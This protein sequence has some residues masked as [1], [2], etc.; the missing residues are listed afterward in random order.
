MAR[1]LDLVKF[2]NPR[3]YF[4]IGVASLGSLLFSS[5]LRSDRP[6]IVASP[7]ET[8]LPQLSA[9]DTKK[10][11][12]PPD[13]LPGARD[14]QSPY[15]SI[16]VYEWGP[17]DGERIL[18][19]H[20]I[21]TP[22]VALTDLAHKLVSKGCRVMLFDLFGRG[23]SSGPSPS[24]HNY[25]S[26]LYTTQIHLVLSSSALS[27]SRSNPFTVIGYSLGGALALDFT[28][29]FPHLVHALIL[30]APGG[31]I[32]HSHTTWKSRL[33]YSTLGI[34]P[35]SLT[36]RLVAKRLWT[37]PETA[38]TIEP[39]PAGAVVEK[40]ET[41]RRGDAVYA[42]S[43]HN[44]LPG[45]AASSVSAVVDWQIQHHAGFVPAFISSIRYA[46]VHGE[47]GRWNVVRE[48]IENG[49]GGLK[50]VW[51]V[52]GESDPIIVAEEIVEDATSALG[53]ENVGVTIVSGVGHEV[54]IERAEEILGVV[55]KAL[56]REG[57]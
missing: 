37:G 16:R 17:E 39:E 28:S 22:S 26:C 13:A 10:L 9:E 44:L 1:I 8:I 47:Q 29:Y 24:T 23:Y 41:K 45:N 51:V 2:T 57:W 50:K 25:D 11:P 21:S 20:G 36:E 31:L 56:G 54:A 38:R 6:R 32:R 19:I 5:T 35:E 43:H 48:N 27:W 4:L 3:F 46:P 15:G 14:V 40:A 33:L 52:L 18:L 55:G 34:I 53:E 42:S 12:Y 7:L 49:V 30:L